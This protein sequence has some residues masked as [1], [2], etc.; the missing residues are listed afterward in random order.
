MVT[1]SDTRSVLPVRAARVLSSFLSRIFFVMAALAAGAVPMMAQEQAGGEA[2]LHLPD[3]RVATFLGGINGH[4]LL[5]GGLLVSALG[6]VFGLVI[7]VRLR[8]MPVHA[9]MF[10]VSELIYET[11]KTYL[12]TQ[13]KFLIWLELCIAVVIVFYFGVLQGMA[14]YKVI[15]IL[16]FSVVG[17][18]ARAASQWPRLACASTP[19]PTRAQHSPRSPARRIPATTFRCRPA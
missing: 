3:L 1:T 15:I 2:N 8:K 13:G 10:E 4:D 19:S 6:L 14:A 18:S 12:S 16:A 9:C 7:F 11:C 5:L 17:I